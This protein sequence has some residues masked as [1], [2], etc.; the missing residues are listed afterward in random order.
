MLSGEVE[1]RFTQID[2]IH[3]QKVTAAANKNP[4]IK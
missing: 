4:K 2:Q 3:R 1:E